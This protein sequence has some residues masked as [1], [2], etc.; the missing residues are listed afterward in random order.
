M[1]WHEEGQELN[2]CLLV[3]NVIVILGYLDRRF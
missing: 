2:K 1:A 3:I